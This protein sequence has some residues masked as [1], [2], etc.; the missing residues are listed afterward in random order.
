MSAIDAAVQPH[1][2]K[3]IRQTMTTSRRRNFQK[4][5]DILTLL[6]LVTTGFLVLFLIFGPQEGLEAMIIIIPWMLAMA[7]HLTL[8]IGALVFA[9][10]TRAPWRNSWI[11]IY[12]LLFFG[13][14]A[15]YLAVAGQ[16]DIFAARKLD[17]FRA[18]DESELY[19]LLRTGATPCSC[20][21]PP[22]TPIAAKHQRPRPPPPGFCWTTAPTAKPRPPGARRPWAGP[23]RTATRLWPAS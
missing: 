2:P 3:S 7:V 12:F 13:F 23:P 16:M 1:K 10:L 19:A 15:Y 20:T 14:N 21:W 6:C 8:G 17:E 5:A 4:L 18:P 22:T 11:Y 9:W